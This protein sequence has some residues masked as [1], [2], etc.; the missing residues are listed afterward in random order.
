M[1][2]FSLIA[3]QVSLCADDGDTACLHWRLGSLNLPT[4]LSMKPAPALPSTLTLVP[5][6]EKSHCNVQGGVRRG[7]SA[8]LELSPRRNSGLRSGSLS[9]SAVWTDQGDGSGGVTPMSAS[10]GAAS[11]PVRE[12]LGGGERTQTLRTRPARFLPRHAMLASYKGGAQRA[13]RSS[14]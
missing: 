14:R 7:S 13:S 11:S 2:C 8:S 10:T 1:C 3:S 9:A 12:T 6:P 5:F 4:N